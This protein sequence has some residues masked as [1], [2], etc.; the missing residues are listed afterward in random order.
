[1]GVGEREPEMNSAIEKD[2]CTE[3]AT[4]WPS[5]N[6]ESH[7]LGPDLEQVTSPAQAAVPS[8]VT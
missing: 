8:F 4:Q 6:L 1:M 7:R 5:N 3:E 2:L